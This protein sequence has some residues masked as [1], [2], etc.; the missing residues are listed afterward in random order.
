MGGATGAKQAWDDRDWSLSVGGRGHTTTVTH[1]VKR[2]GPARD[3]EFPQR[4]G[5]PRGY[6]GCGDIN[7][8]PDG[9]GRHRAR[10]T[11]GSGQSLERVAWVGCGARLTKD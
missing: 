5:S 2:T 7:Q 4:E 1:A 11:L 10:E 9:Q 3:R 6:F 8:T